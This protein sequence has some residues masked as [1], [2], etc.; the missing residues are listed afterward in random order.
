DE[1]QITAYIELIDL[2][3]K[4][5]ALESA[6]NV[7]KKGN[8]VFGD[9]ANFN[10]IEAKLYFDLGD[11]ESALNVVSDETLKAKILLQDE[12]ND[13]AKTIL[14]KMNPNAMEK[15]RKALYFLL[16]A[17]YSYNVKN[18]DEAFKYIDEYIKILGPNP[19]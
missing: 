18:F 3:T 12:K 10:D 11:Y 13:E 6:I 2:Y 15:E 8:D 4:E 9:R 19:I 16:M 7:A 5:K 17:Q 1:N 14:D